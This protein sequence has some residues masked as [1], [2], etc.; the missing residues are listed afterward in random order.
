MS[1]R[2]KNKVYHYTE[3]GKFIKTFECENDVRKEYYS[4]D[5]GQ[6]PLFIRRSGTGVGNKVYY[7]NDTTITLPDGT[8]ASKE[9][10]GRDGVFNYIK[11][12]NSSYVGIADTERVINV[13]NLDGKVIATFKGLYVASLMTGIPKGTIHHQ[14]N[15]GTKSS[16]S[17][18]IFRYK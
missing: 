10:I 1:G 7:Y 15:K 4:K 13:S 9:R 17:D 11:K 3:D 16:Q 18:L 8:I 2:P 14:I 5:R 6:R 12:S